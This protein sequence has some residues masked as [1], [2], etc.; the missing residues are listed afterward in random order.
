[1]NIKEIDDAK[2]QQA[3]ARFEA[4]HG[5]IEEVCPQFVGLSLLR[6]N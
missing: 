2:L 5:A 4:M 3:I 1:M 6:K